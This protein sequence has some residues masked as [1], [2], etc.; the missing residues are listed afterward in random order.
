MKQ[1]L[2]RWIL[3]GI[4][5]LP[6]AVAIGIFVDN[7]LVTV[8]LSYSVGVIFMLLTDIWIELVQLKKENE[9]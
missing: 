6:L 1:E 5:A 3:W 9:E 8:L 2:A 4:M 7:I